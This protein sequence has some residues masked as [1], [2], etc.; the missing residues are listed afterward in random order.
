M[1]KKSNPPPKPPPSPKP[2]PPPPKDKKEYTRIQNDGG[3]IRKPTT[4]GKDGGG[5]H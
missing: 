1:A 4:D 5:G 2:H 3:T